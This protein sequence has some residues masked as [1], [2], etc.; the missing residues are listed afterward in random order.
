MNDKIT[1]EV[2]ENVKNACRE[3]ELHGGNISV[4]ESDKLSELYKKA[5]EYSKILKP[6]QRKNFSIIEFYGD[7]ER[8]PACFFR[9]HCRTLEPLS[10]FKDEYDS[11]I[12]ISFCISDFRAH[13]EWGYCR[14]V[15]YGKKYSCEFSINYGDIVHVN[16]Q[17]GKAKFSLM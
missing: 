6:G 4:Q 2:S 8:V 16:A 9:R 11:T 10:I 5:L 17:G 13:E 1:N 7:I 15:K 14:I 3:Y 12:L